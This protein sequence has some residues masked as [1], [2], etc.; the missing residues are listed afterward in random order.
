MAFSP[1]GVRLATCGDKTTQ[2]WDIAG[3]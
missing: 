3:G 2:I 1:D